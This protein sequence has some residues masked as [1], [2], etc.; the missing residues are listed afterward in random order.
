MPFVTSAASPIFPAVVHRSKSRIHM[1]GTAIKY[2]LAMLIVLASGSLALGQ[3]GSVGGSVGKIDKSISGDGEAPSS[4]KRPPTRP[5]KPNER[6][7]SAC[8]QI[9]AS[10]TGTWH[11]SSPNAV[12]E[13]IRQTGCNF[14]ATISN[15]FF[16]HTI[17][18]HYLD[19]SNFSETIT[20]TNRITGCTTLMFGRM[21][22]ISGAQMQWIITR[23]DG[24]CDLLV[25]YHET[26]TWTR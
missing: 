23:T 10:I 5:I 6:T 1:S 9:V 13:D 22:V 19:G 8:R 21:T 25:N 11:S 2:F 15:Q 14:V 12:S 24:K 3:A 26:R 20:R 7:G 4:R 18:G 17:S 16:D